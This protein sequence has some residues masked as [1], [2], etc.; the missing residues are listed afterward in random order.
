MKLL[1]GFA[2]RKLIVNVGVMISAYVVPV[3]LHNHGLSDSV[4]LAALALI[5]SASAI[6]S[7]ANVKDSKN[8][9]A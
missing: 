9:Q 2:S 4:V 6:Y 8:G 1:K 5:G 3:S 7:A